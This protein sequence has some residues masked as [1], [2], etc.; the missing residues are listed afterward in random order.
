MI[1]PLKSQMTIRRY[2]T[3]LTFERTP[4]DSSLITM[5]YFSMTEQKDTHYA[6]VTSG[7]K[8]KSN[9]APS[10]RIYDILLKTHNLFA[11]RD[12]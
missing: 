11:K 8:S 5:S 6:C 2:L 1:R 10:I 3:E 12:D 4:S 7:N 9:H